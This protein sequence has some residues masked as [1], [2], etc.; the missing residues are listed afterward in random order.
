MNLRERAVKIIERL[1]AR[2]THAR[3]AA[4]LADLREVA[5]EAAQIAV[6]EADADWRRNKTATVGTDEFVTRVLEEM[7]PKEGG[8]E[9]RCWPTRS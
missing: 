7:D 4:M 9:E 3:H 5:R 1:G 6:A 2:V 8:P